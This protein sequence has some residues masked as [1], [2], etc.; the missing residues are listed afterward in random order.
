MPAVPLVLIVDDN[1]RNRKLAR[2]VLRLAG[3]RILEA[4]TA[5]EGIALASENLP[6][7]ILM[8]LRLPDLDGS[9]AAGMLRAAPR[10]SGIPVV[11]LTALPLD[12]RD[13]WLFDAGFAGYLRKP[14]DIDALPDAVRRFCAR[15][16]G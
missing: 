16:P 8:D 7:V 1:A 9:V 12:P 6:D 11:A 5:A 3:F 15:A 13:D 2:D 4:A 10:T 14:I